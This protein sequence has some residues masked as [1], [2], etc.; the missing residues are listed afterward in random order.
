M[1]AGKRS[2]STSDL[3]QQS[4]KHRNG[5][6]GVRKEVAPLLQHLKKN[7]EFI[8][9]LTAL[10]GNAQP[11]SD[12]RRELGFN[13]RGAAG[14][15]VVHGSNFAP[16]TTAEDIRSFVEELTSQTCECTILTASPTVIA[17]MVFDEK[18]NA[19]NVIQR[20]NNQKV[21]ITVL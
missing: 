5:G 2:V 13:I 16:G 12:N 15:F 3:R 11:G 9:N 8:S 20:L 14:P 18:H 4:E 21:R 19:E 17:E 6:P 1:G 7:N 10:R